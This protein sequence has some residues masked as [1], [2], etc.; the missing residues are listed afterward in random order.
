[1]TIWVLFTI[2][3]KKTQSVIRLEMAIKEKDTNSGRK[4]KLFLLLRGN[5]LFILRL[6]S[7]VENP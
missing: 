1:M 3:K 4:M 6:L 2:A 5:K 7:D